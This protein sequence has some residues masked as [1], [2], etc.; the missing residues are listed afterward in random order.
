MFGA[1]RR[2]LLGGDMSTDETGPDEVANLIS[3][4]LD[5]V[6]TG[7]DVDPLAALGVASP[8]AP[9]SRESTPPAATAPSPPTA[10]APPA[11]SPP[12]APAPPADEEPGPAAP[13]AVPPPVEDQDLGPA[14][15]LQ[16][17]A[18]LIAADQ[19][20]AR[21]WYLMGLGLREK[22]PKT[23]IGHF[24]KAVCLD[25]GE[26]DYRVALAGLLA[27]G[28]AHAEAIEV[29]D[30]EVVSGDAPG[31]HLARA[32]LLLRT[33]KTEEA[34]RLIDS[35]R[36]NRGEFD[37]AWKELDALCAFDETLALG[38]EHAPGSGRWV[39]KS[40]EAIDDLEEAVHR[41]SALATSA[42]LKEGFDRHLERIAEARKQVF[43]GR[44]AVAGFSLLLGLVLLM[45]SGESD[46]AVLLPLSILYIVCCPAYLLLARGPAWR[47]W[48]KMP[49]PAEPADSAQPPGEAIGTWMGQHG[50]TTLSL[51][52]A[53]P[54]VVVFHAVT[55]PR[56]GL[57]AGVVALF[58]VIGLA[59]LLGWQGP[60]GPGVSAPIQP[61]GGVRQ[62]APNAR[63]PAR[64]S[65]PSSPQT[66]RTPT[67]SGARSPG[68]PRPGVDVAGLWVEFGAYTTATEKSW[69]VAGRPI[70]QGQALTD[71]VGYRPAGK[72][73]AMW[74]PRVFDGAVAEILQEG[75]KQADA[76]GQAV[77]ERSRERTLA[78]GGPAVATKS[79]DG[80]AVARAQ[81]LYHFPGDAQGCTGRETIH[82][83][84]GS[85]L[86]LVEASC[87][88]ARG[89]FAQIQK[90]GNPAEP[91]YAS[92]RAALA[93]GRDAAALADLRKCTELDPALAGCWWELGWTQWKAEDW[94]AVVASWQRVASLNSRFPELRTWLPKAKAK[95]AGR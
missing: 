38:W 93:D 11:A 47:Q 32:D 87:P 92:G 88:D 33:G 69:K 3:A 94:S 54:L 73:M 61:Q 24:R 79:A 35:S 29:L 81:R 78:F 31:T 60:G 19:S 7:D 82:H 36:A 22:D 85:V 67:A 80:E 70:H 89:L 57:G 20:D 91:L 45:A 2:N 8:G 23:S 59:W 44:K 95:A 62:A 16:L 13:E 72:S 83:R 46:E 76:T 63:P 41:A 84:D 71:P 4:A 27:A 42:S 52:A 49:E 55:G 17:G 34:R 40:D 12:T 86:S 39:P 30:P 25:G 66:A 56:K 26:P 65:L 14:E 21:G 18:R 28:G 68:S 50:P 53:A 5:R 75:P 77:F 37:A 90:Y 43:V 6:K 58:A 48:A 74:A 9:A 10:P 51:A 15:Q 64:A 1:L